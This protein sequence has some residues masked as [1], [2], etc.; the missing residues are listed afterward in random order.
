MCAARLAGE[1]GDR[2]RRPGRRSDR[3]LVLAFSGLFLAA[4]LV[5][6]FL[7]QYRYLATPCHCIGISQLELESHVIMEI[8]LAIRL[9]NPASSHRN[10]IAPP[11]HPARTLGSII[12]LLN[13]SLIVILPRP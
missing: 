8:H 9:S 4:L 7:L 1:R 13:P 3:G 10:E 12:A 5:S 6:R 11:A 2:A